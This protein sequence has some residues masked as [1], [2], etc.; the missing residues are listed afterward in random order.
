M[1]LMKIDEVS[2]IIGSGMVIIAFFIIL[3]VDSVLGAGIH[4][5]ADAISVPYFIRVRAYDVV[6]MIGFLTT[7]SVSKLLG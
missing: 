5:V 7:I 6:V 2:R 4:L 3:H 1:I